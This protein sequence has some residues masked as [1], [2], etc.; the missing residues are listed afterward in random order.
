[1]KDIFGQDMVVG[2]K[3]LVI[4]SR[5]SS[6]PWKRIGTIVGFTSSRIK[7]DCGD[8]GMYRYSSR[9]TKPINAQKHQLLVV[10]EILPEGTENGSLRISQD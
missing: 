3:V 8:A 5:T 1:M 6:A 4:T 9:E 2:M 7:V 10:D